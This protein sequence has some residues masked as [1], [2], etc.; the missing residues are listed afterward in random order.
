MR[1]VHPFRLRGIWGKVV[2]GLSGFFF[3]FCAYWRFGVGFFCSRLGSCWC[4][5]SGSR[6]LGVAWL[7][8][9]QLDHLEV[10]LAV[11]NTT[12]LFGDWVYFSW[13]L[14]L[15]LTPY[16]LALVGQP[17]L[18]GYYAYMVFWVKGASWRNCRR[19]ECKTSFSPVCVFLCSRYSLKKWWEKVLWL[20]WV[21]KARHPGPFS[22]SM[23][24]E[25]FNVGGWL[26]GLELSHLWR[27]VVRM[28]S[29]GSVR[30]EDYVAAR[31]CGVGE[32]RRLVAGL[33]DRVS[34]FIRG[35]VAHRRITGV[36]AWRNCLREDP[37]VHP[38]RWLR[39]DRLP[40]SP[41]LQCDRAL[42]PG[43][44]EANTTQQ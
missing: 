20:L 21:G 18:H 30:V 24:V 32:S 26:T 43:G 11:H 7:G 22:G 10:N 38:Y 1:K 25:V 5:F 39:A 12:F 34:T 3:V 2:F 37:L 6:P 41:F 17:G 16:L 15:S 33:Y 9:C 29:L 28:G 8:H 13:G 44:S 36:T 42:T 27:C 31:S 23:S 4:A 40:P 19:K 35:I 14:F